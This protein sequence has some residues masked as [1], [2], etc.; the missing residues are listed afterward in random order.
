MLNKAKKKRAYENASAALGG[1]RGLAKEARERLASAERDVAA[2][3]AKADACRLP[4]G[5]RRRGFAP[6]RADV[7]VGGVRVRPPRAA[8][9]P[10][11]NEGRGDPPAPRALD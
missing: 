5:A 8:P 11:A 3:E 4:P 2:A 9:R 1:A 7:A 6:G 10:G